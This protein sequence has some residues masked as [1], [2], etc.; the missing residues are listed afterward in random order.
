MSTCRQ[1]VCETKA[2]HRTSL[3]EV[4][5]KPWSDLNLAIKDVGHGITAAENAGTRLKIGEV[6][7]GHLK[8]A[9]EYSESHGGRS[10]D[11]SSMYGV[12]RK[13]AGLDF[14]TDL[15]KERDA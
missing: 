2:K 4:D 8:E 5:E 13:E 11:S 6:V 1:R 3:I 14:E 12:I 10:L 15:V 7:L 9:K